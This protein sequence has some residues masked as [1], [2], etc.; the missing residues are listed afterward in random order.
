MS[1]DADVIVVGAGPA[2][3]TAARARA[4]RGVRVALLERHV[5]PRNKPC[6][7]GITARV[8]VRFPDVAAA[9]AEIPVHTVSRMS[10][11]APGGETATLTSDRPAVV[12]I[13][14][15]DFD[16][17][18]ARM[19]V[20][21]GAQLLQGVAAS[22]V[23]PVDEGVE[24]VDRE[25]R[26]LRARYVVGA[27]GVNGI[28]ARRVGLNPGWRPTSVALDMMEETPADVLG[29][30]DSDRLWVSYGH[31]T[32]DGYAYIFPKREH[33]NVGIGYRLSYYR[34]HVAKQPYS[35]QEDLVAELR[36]AGALRGRSSRQHFTPSLVPI[37]GPVRRT[38]C[39]RVLLAGD[40]A[41]F[42][43]AYTAEGIYYAMVSGELAARAIADGEAL[44]RVASHYVRLWRREIGA[45]LRDSV[46]IQQYLFRD[47]QR[48]T[49]LVR[50]LNREP[51]IGRTIVAYA[52]G[53]IAYPQARRRILARF[54]SVAL[55][56]AR[57]RLSR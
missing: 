47:P 2:G 42:V 7:G 13:R 1:F 56:L 8:L 41:G 25:G 10:L 24:V 29:C 57:L 26:T 35:L 52:T 22:R 21:A 43:N 36:A 28:V 12:L 9:L 55:R 19:A 16:Y 3:S 45:E 30:V 18:L 34:E 5:F 49:R 27:D 33:V 6:G 51:G 23:T 20:Q 39:G 54:P 32:A 31:G 4:Q 48:I 37:G 14:R 15:W 46:L 17:L 53:T 38:A 40:A 50:A 44:G 11:A